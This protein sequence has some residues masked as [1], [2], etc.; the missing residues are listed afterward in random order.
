[1]G[2]RINTNTASINAQNNLRKTKLELDSALEKLSSGY[3]V[4]KAADDAAGLAI[5]SKMEAEIRGSQQATRNANDG[6]S[7]IQ[8]AEGA[9]NEVTNI[10]IR[11]R[12][13]GVQ[14]SSDTIGD[15]ERGFINI[16]LNQLKEEI[17]RISQVTRFNDTKLLSGEAG[18]KEIQVGISDDIFEDRLTLDMSQNNATLGNLG[19]EGISY[20]E[21]GGAQ[22][23]MGL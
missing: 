5:S 17:Q 10:L 19:I 3:R 2:L 4:N 13:L 21:K 20:E 1:M 15:T 12:E 23:A 18:V 11:L 8:V 7:M 14:A 16:E 6:V 22:E 9:F